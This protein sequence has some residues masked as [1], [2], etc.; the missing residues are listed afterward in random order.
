MTK[1]TMQKKNRK[2]GAPEQI[3]A[4]DNQIIKA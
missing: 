3:F 2:I 4:T 1:T